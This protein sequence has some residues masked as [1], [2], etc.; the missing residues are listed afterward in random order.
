MR[1]FGLKVNGDFDRGRFSN[2]SVAA[3]VS[4]SSNYE[5]LPSQGLAA[6]GIRAWCGNSS[7]T[8]EA[9]WISVLHKFTKQSSAQ[10]ASGLARR[11]QWHHMLASY[12]MTAWHCEGRWGINHFLH[13]NDLSTSASR[14][15]N[16]LLVGGQD[17]RAGDPRGGAQPTRLNCC[18]FCLENRNRFAETLHHVVFVCPTYLD[19]RGSVADQHVFASEDPR[20]FCL[21]RNVWSWKE[22]KSL[23]KFFLTLVVKRSAVAGGVGKLGWKALQL[24]ADHAWT[25]V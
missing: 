4:I 9:S 13:N 23:R 2:G 24:R 10:T 21:H 8:N 15:L 22:L 19:V 18:I 25:D 11:C 5:S 14:S 17:F 20:L 12:S 3:K 7:P 16:R 6:G 1:R